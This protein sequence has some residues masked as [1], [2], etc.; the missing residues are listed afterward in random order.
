MK[1]DA[2]NLGQVLKNAREKRQLHR[3]SVAR[4]LG[5]TSNYLGMIERG[6]RV[7]TVDLL[8]SILSLYQLEL[9]V[10]LD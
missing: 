1:I 6:E 2:S 3:P 10:D 7:P 8:V 9:T 4:E 5:V